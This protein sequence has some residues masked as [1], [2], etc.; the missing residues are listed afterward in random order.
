MR[1]VLARRLFWRNSTHGGYVRGE[2]WL[3]RDGEIHF[4]D[5]DIGEQGHVAVATEALLDWDAV[6]EGLFEAGLIDEEQAHWIESEGPLEALHSFTWPDAVGYAAVEKPEIWDMIKSGDARE[7]FMKHHGAIMVIGGVFSSWR[8]TSK[9]IE[10][11]Q[12][13]VLEEY[14]DEASPTMEIWVEAFADAKVASTTWGEFQFMSKP[15]EL[16]WRQG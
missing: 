10:A 2:W 8:V 13:F 15:S 7:A 6:A 9:T 11:I 16:L 1:K 5:Q 14:G 3:T 4:A 12:G